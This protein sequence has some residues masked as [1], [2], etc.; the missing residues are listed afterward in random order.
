MEMFLL[1]FLFP[2]KML[3]ELSFVVAAFK[4]FAINLRLYFITDFVWGT[5]FLKISYD[6]KLQYHA[7]VN[8]TKNLP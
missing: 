1:H 5:I 7:R 6:N 3:K 2:V 8:Q 4:F